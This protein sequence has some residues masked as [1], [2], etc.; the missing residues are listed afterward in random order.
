MPYRVKDSEDKTADV[1]LGFMNIK[2]KAMNVGMNV[3]SY[4]VIFAQGKDSKNVQKQ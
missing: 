3:N 2:S 1:I 4:R